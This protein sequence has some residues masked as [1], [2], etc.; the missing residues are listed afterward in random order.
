VLG[1]KTKTLL[2]ALLSETT[3]WYRPDEIGAT[4]D[5]ASARSPIAHRTVVSP[6]SIKAPKRTQSHEDILLTP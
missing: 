1:S 3:I 6:M 4:G 5:W 2:P